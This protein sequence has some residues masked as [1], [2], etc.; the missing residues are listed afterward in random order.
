MFFLDGVAVL[1]LS[2][3][4]KLLILIQ[5]IHLDLPVLE[6]S[7]L[8]EAGIPN[9]RKFDMTI[10]NEWNRA[11][12]DETSLSLILMDIDFFKKFNDNYG[13]AM[14]DDCLKKV[15][16]TIKKALNRASDFAARYGGEE[17]ASVLPNC[18]IEGAVQTA[19]V[20]RKAVFNLNIPH[21]QS[22][23]AEWVTLSLGTASIYPQKEDSPLL[24]IKSADE[25]LYKAKENGRNRVDFF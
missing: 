14:G 11:S 18:D 16:R 5:Y 25:A 21:E 24:L 15:A 6:Q 19:Q 22:K 7:E 2:I 1:I 20:I 9:R 12:R 3:L 10:E 8:V 23:A 4:C 13:H 17:F